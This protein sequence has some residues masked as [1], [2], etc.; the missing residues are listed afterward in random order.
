MLKS[1]MMINSLLLLYSFTKVRAATAMCSSGDIACFK[2]GNKGLI[3][4]GGMQDTM[5]HF[6]KESLKN[7]LSRG[8]S[9]SGEGD[10]PECALQ[11]Q[12]PVLEGVQMVRN[13][14]QTMVDQQAVIQCEMEKKKAFDKKLNAALRELRKPIKKDTKQKCI[15]KF[16]GPAYACYAQQVMDDF[17]GGKKWT[18]AVHNN[19]A[20]LWKNEGKKAKTLTKQMVYE[21][22][23]YNVVEKPKACQSYFVNTDLVAEQ[24]AMGN[25]LKVIGVPSQS[26][27]RAKCNTP[28][29]TD[30][31]VG[32]MSEGSGRTCY[33]TCDFPGSIFYS[34]NAFNSATEAEL[35][36]KASKRKAAPAA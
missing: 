7:P 4:T 29:D 10:F 17:I 8:G 14:G 6:A 19:V 2:T 32:T 24:N 25:V 28:C 16:D 11:K 20:Q 9:N 13:G 31:K 1:P 18:V 22:L 12:S 27:Q 26:P 30:N 21:T 36:K 15:K 33:N 5:M 23:S 34:E 35:K 3:N